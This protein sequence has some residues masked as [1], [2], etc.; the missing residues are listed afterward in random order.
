MHAAIRSSGVWLRP[1]PP[2]PFADDDM[3]GDTK[4]VDLDMP[5]AGAGGDDRGGPVGKLKY[6]CGTCSAWPTAVNDWLG[7]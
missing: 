1:P 5:Q 2:P 3:Q 4:D 7:P 6:F